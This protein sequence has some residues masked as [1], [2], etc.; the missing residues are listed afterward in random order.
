MTSKRGTHPTAVDIR[1]DMIWVTLQDQRVIG[2]PLV[3]F[4]WLAVAT[5]EQRANV[6]RS[7]FSIFWPDLDDGIDI[8]ALLVG[9]WSAPMGENQ[10]DTFPA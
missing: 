4:P 10:A 6:E 9:N 3:W 1:D 8:E 7:A 5:A 2:A